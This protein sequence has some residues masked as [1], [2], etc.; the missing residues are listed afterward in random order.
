MMIAHNVLLTR[1][2]AL[3]MY[4]LNGGCWFR[5]PNDFNAEEQTGKQDG[6]TGTSSTSNIYN[7]LLSFPTWFP[8]VKGIVFYQKGVTGGLE[9]GWKVTVS[10]AWISKKNISHWLNILLKWQL[11]K[12]SKNLWSTSKKKMQTTL[13]CI[14]HARAG[15][16][17]PHMI[18]PCPLSLCI[19]PRRDPCTLALLYLTGSDLDVQSGLI[20]SFL[21]P[22]LHK[23]PDWFK[24]KTVIDDR[25]EGLL[26]ACLVLTLCR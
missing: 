1:H 14:D 23:K 6:S 25:E 2:A 19:C 17:S 5:C 18:R 13:R 10:L 21:T 11:T 16:N 9:H 20:C 8:G 24:N 15:E 12:L 3:R 7:P 26:I 22:H 4:G